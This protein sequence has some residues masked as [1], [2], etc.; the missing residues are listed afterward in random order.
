MSQLDGRVLGAD[1]QSAQ[2][3]LARFGEHR[4]VTWLVADAD[5]S[6]WVEDDDTATVREPTLK[7]P[8]EIL[9][10]QVEDHGWAPDRLREENLVRQAKRT[11][12]PNAG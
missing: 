9:E 6:R 10:A 4:T 3:N 5:L 12:A 1:A 8:V 2:N 7:M 11:R